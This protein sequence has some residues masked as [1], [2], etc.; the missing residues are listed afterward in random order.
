M[1]EVMIQGTSIQLK[2]YKGK[3]VVTLKDVDVVHQRPLG[4]AK[5]NFNQNRNRFISGVDF[6]KVSANEFRTHF[7]INHSKQ[8]VESVTL[9]TETGYLMLVKSFTD[10]L[11]WKVQRELV[12]T[13][14]R[15][16]DEEQTIEQTVTITEPVLQENP[17]IYLEASKIMSGCLEG[18][19]PYVLNILRHIVPDIDAAQLQEKV[20]EITTEITTTT[21]KRK[22]NRPPFWKE[23]VEIDVDRL[24]LAL[25]YKHMTPS[26]LAYKVGVCVQTANSW[27]SGKNKPVPEN[28]VKICAVLGEAEDFLTPRRTRRTR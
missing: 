2:E 8:A 16:K 27:V 6:F 24:K 23:G 1:N 3:R 21:D 11:A 9:I 26:D 10:D 12:D 15:V 19:R 18:N 28:L 22:N 7:D 20:T 17:D 25:N 14:F 13:Y 5:R 4:T